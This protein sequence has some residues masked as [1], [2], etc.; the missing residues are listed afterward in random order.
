VTNIGEEMGFCTFELKVNGRV[1]DSVEIPSFEGGVTATQ[2]FELTRG[3]GT[4]EVEVEG[5]T[6]SF[7]IFTTPEPPFWTSPE[8]VMVV[9]VIIA[10]AVI[11]YAYWKGILP[12]ATTRSNSHGT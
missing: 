12:S 2:F 7:T 11:L 1:V 8:F 9:S 6:G 4:Y 5:L 3:A 10:A